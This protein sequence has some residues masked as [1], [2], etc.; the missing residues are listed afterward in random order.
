MA[1]TFARIP[2]QRA[3]VRVAR[4]PT[5]RPRPRRRSRPGPSPGTDVEAMWS[6]PR[7][8]RFSPPLVNS[9]SLAQTGERP[10]DHIGIPPRSRPQTRCHNVPERCRL[11]R[12]ARIPSAW[13]QEPTSDGNI[14][15]GS[16]SDLHSHFVSPLL[17]GSA[18]PSS[19]AWAAPA[20]RLR[21]A[22]Q[23]RWRLRFRSGRGA[24]PT[25]EVADD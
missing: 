17:R 23:C 4:C 22:R 5:W 2:G 3:S 16:A 13:V 7:G 10:S 8:T 6:S 19:P 21:S 9:R 20:A 12:T 25:S 15:F 1:C 14:V 11:R 18:V 24:Q